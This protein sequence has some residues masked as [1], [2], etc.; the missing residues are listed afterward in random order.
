MHADAG[1]TE[2]RPYQRDVIAKCDRVIAAGKRCIIIV[3]PTGS[4]KTIKAVAIIKTFL[5][6][7]FEGGR[8]ERR[9]EK[10]HSLT[11]K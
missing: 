3:A 8:H 4:G 1:M 5:S 2:L 6:T 11:G 9:V 7:P 10:I